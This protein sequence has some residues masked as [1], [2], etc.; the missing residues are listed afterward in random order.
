MS[1]RIN[2]LVRRIPHI[3]VGLIVLF[4]VGCLVKVAIWEHVYYSEKEGSTRHSIVEVGV[5]A[6]DV[7][8]V[9]ETEV[10]TEQVKA[11]TVPSD[12]PRYL[13]GTFMNKTMGV[14]AKVNIFD[15]GL[16]SSGAMATRASI[17]EIA[18]YRDSSKPG[19]GGTVLINGHNSGPTK[20]GV[21]DYLQDVKKGDIITIERGDGLLFDY[22]VYDIESLLIAEANAYMPN[23]MQSPVPGKESLSLISCTGEWSQN[24]RTHLSRIMVRAVLVENAPIED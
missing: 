2:S 9:D 12:H 23:M 11:H 7:Q 24:Q 5:T 13:I 22:E 14:N 1:L 16:T 18:W 17:F 6:P 19:Y 15:V 3:I 8:E 20:R 10:T 21:F 4:L